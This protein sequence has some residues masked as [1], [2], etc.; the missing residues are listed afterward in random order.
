MMMRLR[1]AFAWGASLSTFNVSTKPTFA[2]A[3]TESEV[4]ESEPY[5]GALTEERPE[6]SF[7]YYMTELD[8]RLRAWSNYKL[9]ST[10]REDKRTLR[11]VCQELWGRQTE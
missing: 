5:H 6:T 4:P 2:C 8:A 7:G 9:T 3:T 1:M 11:L 10:S